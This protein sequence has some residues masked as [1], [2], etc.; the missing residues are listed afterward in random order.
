[1][2]KHNGYPE[3]NIPRDILIKKPSIPNLQPS[4]SNNDLATQTVQTPILSDSSQ[5]PISQSGIPTP[6]VTP[7]PNLPEQKIATLASLAT[8]A[9]NLLNMPQPL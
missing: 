4:V 1:M 5:Q 3:V 8:E 9:L 7:S 6:A 2:L